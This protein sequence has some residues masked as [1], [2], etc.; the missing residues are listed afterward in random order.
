MRSELE[1]K[2]LL[3]SRMD[4]FIKAHENNLPEA[5]HVY[6]ILID[7]IKW[8]LNDNTQEPNNE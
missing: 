2:Q 7:E 3:L 1:V 6:Q 8:I 4:S 5:A